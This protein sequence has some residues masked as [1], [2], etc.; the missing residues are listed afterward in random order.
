MKQ[1]HKTDEMATNHIK[2]GWNYNDA[3]DNHN[4]N[5]TEY[6]QQHSYLLT[7]QRD[8]FCNLT[9]DMYQTAVAKMSSCQVHAISRRGMDH[10]R[11]IKFILGSK[12]RGNKTKKCIIH[13]WASGWFLLFYSP[14]PCSQVWILI[15]RN[16]SIVQL[17][18]S[19]GSS[20]FLSPM[21]VAGGNPWPLVTALSTHSP[22]PSPT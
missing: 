1:Q 7:M 13:C 22:P 8:L 5:S 3:K 18:S 6:Q 4:Y 19:F 10:F 11:Y 21:K 12:A 14:K 9:G 2:M 15:Y 17:G 20:F 16:W